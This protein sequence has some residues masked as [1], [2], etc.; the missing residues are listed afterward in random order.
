MLSTT[1]TIET[2][3]GSGVITGGFL[4]N[5]E[6]TDF[7]FAP[8]VDGAGGQPGRGRQ[9]P[10]SSMAPTMVLK[11]GAPMLLI[12]SPGGANIIPFV[13]QALI[14]ILDF[15]QDPG[16]RSTPARAEPHARPR[17]RRAQRRSDHRPWQAG[18]QP[19]AAD[20]NS[21]LQAILIGRRHPDRRRRQAR[22]QTSDERLTASPPR[23]H[24]ATPQASRS[25]V[26]DQVIPCSSIKS[27]T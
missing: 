13:A 14:G 10:R 3:F 21:G 20:L 9:A 26:N 5:N 15:G 7:A 2:D 8:E 16:G 19:E 18:Q 4:L 22:R 17:S 11:D 23:A 27:G 24:A 6:L 1:T 12:G 25:V